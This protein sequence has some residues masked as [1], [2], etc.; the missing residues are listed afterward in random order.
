MSIHGITAQTE[1]RMGI[2][3]GEIDRLN[4]TLIKEHDAWKI[5]K[6]TRAPQ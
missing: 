1:I 2:A 4:V 6:V 3:P 5:R